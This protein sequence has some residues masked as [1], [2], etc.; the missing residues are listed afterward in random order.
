MPVIYCTY[1]LPV[2]DSVRETESQEH[3]LGR[4]L[5]LS[6]LKDLYQIQYS[7]EELPKALR[8]SPTGK[9]ALTDYPEIHFNISHCEGLVV[10]A[11]SRRP[12]GID[13]EYPGEFQDILIKK[14]FSP[15]EKYFFYK[16]AD[17]E[18]LRIQWFFRFWTL[19]EAYV[20]K[21]GTGIDMPLTDL[22]FS[23]SNPGTPFSVS[24]SDTDT[25][26]WQHTLPSGH[27]LSACYE[28]AEEA[29]TVSLKFL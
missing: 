12:I 22:T 4:N 9:P 6:G 17:T 19:K 7:P 27:I 21:N 10:C 23:F 1:Y 3:F 2:S 13:A 8:I 16:T 5:L 11:F 15:K 20:K 25:T 29:E 26:C 14:V 18:S 24:C 28:S